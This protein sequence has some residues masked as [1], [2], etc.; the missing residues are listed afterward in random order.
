VITTCES[1]LFQLLEDSANPKF[2]AV[3]ALIKEL[4]TD[5]GLV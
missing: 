4:P 3:Q 1:I 2:K 5:P